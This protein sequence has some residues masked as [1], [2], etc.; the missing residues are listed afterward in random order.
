MQD[1]R[2]DRCEMVYR[3]IRVDVRSRIWFSLQAEFRARNCFVELKRRN[4]YRRERGYRIFLNSSFP[5]LIRS[6]KQE[7]KSKKQDSRRERLDS[8]GRCFA[9]VTGGLMWALS[10]E[11]L[12]LKLLRC[13]W[14][15]RRT[16]IGPIVSEGQQIHDD[17]ALVMTSMR[18]HW[19]GKH[20]KNR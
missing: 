17:F 19:P 6:K 10:V 11:P 2:A 16:R 8:P 5:D 20:P 13:S 1:N 12:L 14:L 15:T 18:R 9:S 7:V 3:R 4:L